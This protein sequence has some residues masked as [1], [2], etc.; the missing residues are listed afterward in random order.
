M[1]KIK[2]IALC[3]LLTLLI[4]ILLTMGFVNENLYESPTSIYQ[5]YL[6][7]NKVGLIN[8][9]DDL[10]SLINEEQ[11]EIKD[12]Y[13]VD[14]VYP[15]KGFQ[16]IKKNTYDSKITTVEEV[17]DSIKDEKTFTI[18]GYTITIKPEVENA[19]PVYIYVLDDK[20]FKTALEN[21]IE[22]FI[23]KERYEQYKTNTQAEI[24]DTGY[25]IENM[26]FKNKIS[27][28]ESYI[29][30]DQKIYTDAGELTKYLLF[31]DNEDTIEYTVVQGDTI[32][33]IAEKHKL[34]VEELL[35]ANEQIKSEDT[36]LAIGQKLNVALIN[37]VLTLIYEELITEDVEEQYQSIIEKDTTKYTDYI[38]V[39]QTGV[40]G[41]N[42]IT[43]RV[44]FI[45]GAQNQGGIIIG[46]PIVI[47]PVQ[48]KITIKGTKKHFSG[49]GGGYIPPGNYV[50]NGQ[51][52]AWPTNS[53][54]I[55]TSPYGYRWGTI[56][57]GIDISGTGGR[58]SPIYASLDGVVVQA[59]YGGIVGRSAGLNVVIDH[60]NGYYTVYA[61]CNKLYVKAGQRV[62]RKQKIAGM[63]A[64]G[65]ATG[66]HLHFG[67][68]K[69]KPYSSGSRALNPSVL[70]R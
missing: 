57:D 43:S 67:L 2:G 50:D 30:V 60:E 41:I 56:H 27:I 28:K 54:Y 7:G 65:T 42:R 32:E 48:N 39:K 5:V 55:I 40:N 68:F 58:N 70:W 49:G 66:I 53:P 22:T 34:N 21:V 36:L 12:E 14:Q 3:S 13:K 8:S 24:I 19:P 51:P 46:E 23:G 6:D 64:T 18:K 35:I 63:G 61:H 9:K 47:R 25:I 69:G 31:G 20:I 10:Y 17:Y 62:T 59:Q 45:N 4:V 11:I 33:L 38:V 29:S 15:P 37:P 1:S 26:Y 44:Q 16:I 52:W